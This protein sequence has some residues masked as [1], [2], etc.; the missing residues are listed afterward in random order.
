MSVPLVTTTPPSCVSLAKS[1]LMRRESCSHWLD[2]ELAAGDVCELLGGQLRNRI[3]A[4]HRANQVFGGQAAA[5][6]DWKSC[7]RSR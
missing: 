3:D 1:S 6:R 2:G 5:R 4:G 7:R